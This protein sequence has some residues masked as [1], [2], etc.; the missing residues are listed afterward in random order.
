MARFIFPRVTKGNR[1]DIASRWGLLHGLHKAGVRDAVV[2]YNLPAD[3]PLPALASFRYLPL[4]QM[5]LHLGRDKAEQGVDTVI[6]SVGLDLQDDSSLIKLILL[7]GRF[8]LYRRMGFR[9]WMVFQGAGPLTTP[10]GKWLAKRVLGQADLFVARDF[11]SHELVG[12]LN[13]RIKRLLAHDAI[14]MPDMEPDLA[15]I[16]PRESE[17][18]AGLFDEKQGPVIGLNI[19]LWFH[20]ASNLLPFQLA[21]QQ[22]LERSS[23]KMDALVASASKFVK[24]LREEHNARIVLVSAYQPGV[25]PWEDDQPWLEK[26]KQGF[27]DDPDVVSLNDPLSMPAYFMLMKKLDLVVGMRLHT[28][29]I[30]LRFGTPAIN[31]NYTLKGKDILSHLGL[32]ENTFELDDF[33]QAPAIV[34]Q[35]IKTVLDGRAAEKLKIE[36]AVQAAIERNMVVLASLVTA[37]ED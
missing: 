33:M 8:W 12:Q 9:I 30:A 28:C 10:F 31:L 21:K 29:L 35:R 17:L 26:I 14:F 16:D 6:W 37:H 22:Y 19:R 36:R 25:V 3:I 5:Q 15:D 32:A 1:G 18:L 20:F 13:P 11:G 4:R 7:W 23:E 34:S 2:Y 27:A 24:I